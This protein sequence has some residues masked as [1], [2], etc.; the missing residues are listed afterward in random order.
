VNGSEREGA[1]ALVVGKLSLASVSLAPA[2]CFS[3]FLPDVS[4]PDWRIDYRPNRD[5]VYGGVR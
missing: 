5:G 2:L 3:P 4:V 1:R